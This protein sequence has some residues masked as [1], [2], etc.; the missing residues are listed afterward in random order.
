MN[1]LRLRRTKNRCTIGDVKTFEPKFSEK[2]LKDCATQGIAAL[3]LFGSRAQGTANEVSDIDIGVLVKNQKTL[4]ETKARSEIYDT[5]YALLEEK[6][7]ERT[8]IDIVFLDDAPAELRA[9]VMKYG[10]VL[11][12]LAP[13]AFTNFR[14]KV[15][16]EYADFAPLRAMFHRAIQERMKSYEQQ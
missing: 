15:M 9:H 4:M 11:A 8:T 2:E 12:E 5:V 1:D 10:R 6:M 14:E 7:N 16:Q 3:I 13:G